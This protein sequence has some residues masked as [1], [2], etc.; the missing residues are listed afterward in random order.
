[1][2]PMLEFSGLAASVGANYGLATNRWNC[3]RRLD[4]WNSQRRHYR[5]FALGYR[6]FGATN[7]KAIQAT[8]AD[9]GTD[10][11]Q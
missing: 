7:R 8:A 5:S 9:T 4:G 11:N 6:C 3:G 2:A 10:S 1:M